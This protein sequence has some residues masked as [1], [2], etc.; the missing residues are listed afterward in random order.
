MT[1][2]KPQ[3]TGQLI[4]AAGIAYVRCLCWLVDRS[5]RAAGWVFLAAVLSTTGLAYFVANH[6]AINPDTTGM[7]SRDLPFQKLNAEFNR[8]FPNLSQNIVVVVDGQTGGLAREAAE[9][10]TRWFEQHP[11]L[12][13]EVY[14]PTAGAFFT[15][16]GLLYLEPTA[17][18]ELSERLSEAQPLLARLAQDP[19]LRGL[20]TLLGEAL[21]HQA[22]DNES[23]PGLETILQE[24]TRTLNALSSGSHYQL[25]WERLMFG[26]PRAQLERRQLILAKPR[27]E[28]NA[29]QP[30]QH[31]ISATQ[32]AVRS[33]GLNREPGVRVRLTGEAVLDNEQLQTATTG[34]TFAVILSITLII[35]LLLVG[36]RNWRFVLA[37][38]VTLLVGLIWTTAFA[39]AIVGP[40]NVISLAFAVL[41]VGIGIDFGIQFCMRYREDFSYTHNLPTALRLSARNM[42]GA[43]SLAAV[44][45]AASFYSFVPTS[46]AGII[47]LGII[48]GTSMLIA[49]LANLTLLPALLTLLGTH[50]RASHF[51]QRLGFAPLLL[52]RS[53]WGITLGAVLAGLAAIPWATQ[54]DFDFDPIRLQDPNSEAVS[55]LR[56]LLTESEYSLYTIEFMQPNL[57]AARQLAARVTA[58]QAVAQA[59][60]L[61]SFIPEDQ[62]DK[63]ARVESLTVIIPPYT[64]VPPATDS[65]PD[66]TELHSALNTF[67]ARLAYWQAH[68]AAD[69]AAPLTGLQQAIDTYQTRFGDSPEN[70]TELQRRIMRTLPTELKR[71]SLALQAQEITLD[72]LP[73]EL[74]ERYLTADGRARVQVFSSLDLNQIPQLRRFVNQVQAVGPQAIG[75]PVLLKEGGDAVITAFRQA[76]LIAVVAILILL[77]VVLRNPW[78][79]LLALAPLALAGLLTVGSMEILAIPFNLANIIVLP[80]LVGLGVAYGIYFVLRWRSGEHIGQVL[81]SSTPT[82]ILFSALTTMSS[83]GSLALASDP[84]VAM[85]G[86]TLSIALGWVLICTLIVLPAVLMLVAPHRNASVERRSI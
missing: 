59:V 34:M 38:L 80:L 81:L 17:L 46:Y 27:P 71:L 83:F 25:S 48:A 32:R 77:L 47:D 54:A 62:A 67:R 68:G 11:D 66:L 73:A 65:P 28:A 12:F 51:K 85:L 69:L 50:P 70:I 78:D 6:F 23:L 36:L 39:V 55:A 29:A 86:R 18:D 1:L 2:D 42:G 4:R 64:L 60:T 82:A 3:R 26:E 33:L 37:T 44:A 49:L 53:A 30:F 24:L 5:R 75:L 43:L 13:S 8:A 56:S 14:Q 21:D 45:A 16:N 61:A 74:R 57:T 31:A 22:T 20:F 41:F 40:F 19:S 76:S 58:L 35:I 79:T 72:N 10:L 52:K 63:L 15:Q 9:R 7:L 84:G